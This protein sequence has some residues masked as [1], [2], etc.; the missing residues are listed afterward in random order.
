M[1]GAL[2][3]KQIIDDKGL[4]PDDVVVVSIMPCTAKK[5]ECDREEMM[6]KYGKD[7]DIVITTQELALMIKEL[8]LK[9]NQLEQASFDMPYGFKTGGGVIFG[10]SGGVAEAAIRYAGEKLTGIKSENYVINAVRGDEDIR[11][12]TITA[13][14]IDLKFAVV[15]GLGNAH[16][17]MKN[18]SEG[19]A[20]YDFVEIMACPGGCING[21][22]QIVSSDTDVK[23]KRTEG[24]YDNDKM[25]QLHNP[26]ENPYVN[27]LYAKLLK[28]PNSHMAHEVLHTTY[29]NRKRIASEGVTL[30]ESHGP[31]ALK[32]SICFGTSCFI[33]G[34][35]NL[36]QAIT[37]FI[38]ENSIE[39]KIEVMAT[40]CFEECDNGPNI[41]VGDEIIPKCTSDMAIK[42]I[43]KQLK[44]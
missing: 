17:I 16:K 3:K 33:K 22:G 44:M 32:V 1:F 30:G 20:Q 19:T 26:Q 23:K 12:A 9:F 7:V 21:G 34:S 15:S 38:H 37:D 42:A 40:F 25:L 14:D 43:K 8:G 41:K 18:I 28:A 39:E 36:L 24:L 31:D 10:N 13:G 35:Q 4:N 27:D 11:E 2:F 29:Q 5:F 6:S